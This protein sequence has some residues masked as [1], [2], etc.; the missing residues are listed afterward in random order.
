MN[1]GGARDK[2]G[3]G[4]IWASRIK[5][6]I[7]QNHFFRARIQEH[8]TH[9]KLYGWYV[10]SAARSWFEASGKQRVNLASISIS[11]AKMLPVP[12]PPADPD[13][14]EAF[15]TLGHRVLTRFASLA[16]ACERDL[17]IGPIEADDKDTL[18]ARPLSELMLALSADFGGALTE[19]EHLAVDVELPPLLRGEA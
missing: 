6:C 4:W 13:D 14:Q 7:H 18:E 1:E 12:V 8:A 11:K 19:L 10:N 16:T 5:D 3:R 17:D 2:L 9:P 15:V